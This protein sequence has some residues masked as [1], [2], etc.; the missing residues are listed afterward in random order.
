MVARGTP[1]RQSS[2]VWRSGQRVAC[3]R[4]RASL[5]A[6]LDVTIRNGVA[7]FV[8]RGNCAGL[9][10]AATSLPIAT[11]APA[12]APRAIATR[13]SRRDRSAEPGLALARGVTL[14]AWNLDL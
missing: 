4:R 12:K 2:A 1:C 14:T 9:G 3:K 10:C 13:I 6:A 7:A 8:A 5:I 11:A